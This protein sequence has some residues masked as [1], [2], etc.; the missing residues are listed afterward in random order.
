M[1]AYV[2]FMN[3]LMTDWYLKEPLIFAIKEDCLS[4][5][6]VSENLFGNDF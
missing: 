2:T 1:H 4:V 3:M 6:I 5:H